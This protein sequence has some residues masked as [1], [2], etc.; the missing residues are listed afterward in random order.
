MINQQWLKKI[1]SKSTNKFT[2]YKWVWSS[3]PQ[4]LNHQK[5]RKKPNFQP[6]KNHNQEVENKRAAFIR[7]KIHKRSLSNDNA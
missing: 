2:V 4:T 6:E 5:N 3:F 1:T 7:E